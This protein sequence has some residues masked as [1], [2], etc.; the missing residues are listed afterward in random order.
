M[1]RILVVDDEPGMRK[2]LA[3]MLRRE[4]Y[5]VA[6]TASVAE[7][8]G[9]LKGEEYALVIADLMMEP[10]NGLDLLT[11]VRRYRWACQ[12]II[13]TAFATPEARTEAASLGAVDFIEKPI[14]AQ[15]LLARVRGL[16]APAS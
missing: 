13:M 1:G 12:V 6:D 10:L 5:D 7:A 9:R 8:L 16:V 15:H 3:M 4:G 11:L 14:L 2:S